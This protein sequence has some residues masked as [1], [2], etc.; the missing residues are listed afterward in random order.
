[1]PIYL[2]RPSRRVSVV[3]VVDQP[4]RPGVYNMWIHFESV[5]DQDFTDPEYYN[6]AKQYPRK[7]PG[8]YR[9]VVACSAVR[10][11]PVVIMEVLEDIEEGVRLGARSPLTPASDQ[12]IRRP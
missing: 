5:T 11:A 9:F 3:E 2:I 6:L 10:S 8:S 12:L 7:W 4:H 1:M